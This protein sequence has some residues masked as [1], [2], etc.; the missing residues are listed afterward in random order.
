MNP[1]TRGRERALQLDQYSISVI[2]SGHPVVR[3]LDDGAW[4]LFLMCQ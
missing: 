2:L 4:R 1:S 3:V